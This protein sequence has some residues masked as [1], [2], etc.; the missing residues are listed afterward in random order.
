M[1]KI[2]SLLL[3]LALF[4]PCALAETPQGIDLALTSTYGDGLSLWMTAGLGETPFC[5]LTL[6]SGQI[7]LAF[8]PDK[9]LCVQSGGQWAQ[10][11]VEGHPVDAALLT[12]PLKLLDGRS[13]SEVLGLLAEDVNKMLDAIPSLYNLPMTLIRDPA[14]AR[15]FSDLYIAA[16]T[17]TISITSE[18]L[19][20]MAASVLGKIYSMEYLDGLNFS[21]IYHHLLASVVQ[22]SEVARAYRS[23]MRGYLLSNFRLSGQIGIDKGE[24]LFSQPYQEPYHL[25]YEQ[26]TPNSWHYLLTTANSDTI[27]GVL[28]GVLYW[29]N[30]YDFALSGYSE[31]QHTAFSVTCSYGSAN[32]FVFIASVDNSFSL[33]IVQAG[34]NFSLRLN[35]ENAN[36]FAL[37]ANVFSLE[38]TSDYI[39]VKIYYNYYTLTITPATDGLDIVA[40]ARTF[41]IFT[42][43]VRTALNGL[44]CTGVYGDTTYRL[45]L[46]ETATGFSLLLS[47]PD[48]DFQLDFAALSDTSCSLTFTDAAGQQV[49][50]T[51]SLCT[52]ESP[53]IPD[54]LGTI[55]LTQLLDDLF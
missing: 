53:V 18:E 11:L 23:A 14:F 36:V 1:R 41:D 6:P 31:N 19:N 27:D 55:E 16:Q 34:S 13:P 12:T 29:R 52:P 10:L 3:M 30:E 20:R 37:N 51:G 43:H 25:T 42:A 4:L 35:N 46:T 28:Y 26:T 40:Q 47:L 8:S 5:S 22:S 32:N 9:G 2:L 17:G 44:I 33:S 54:T 7:N 49:S 45:A 38:S 15:L 50:L 48:E 39:R 21:D 24:L